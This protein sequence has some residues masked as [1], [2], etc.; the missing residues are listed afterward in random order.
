MYGLFLP[1]A[2]FF[3]NTT[4]IDI[5]GPTRANTTL[6]STLKTRQLS[7]YVSFEERYV[8]EEY[9]FLATYYKNDMT[10]I[11]A[12]L[13]LP[14]RY[15]EYERGRVLLGFN[16]SALN[17]DTPLILGNYEDLTAGTAWF[18]NPTSSGSSALA[19][20]EQDSYMEVFHSMQFSNNEY[21]Y[22]EFEQMTLPY[23]PYFS[24]CYGYDSYIPISELFEST[25]CA[26]PSDSSTSIHSSRY[27]YDPIPHQDDI[28]SVGPYDF[29]DRYP[30]ADWCELNFTCN[31]EEDLSLVLIALRWFEHATG[32]TL[33][34]LIDQPLSYANFTGRD[35]N[36]AGYYDAGSGEIIDTVTETTTDTLIN[37][38]VD[39]S[40]A[41]YLDYDC[42]S[43]CMPRSVQL[44]VGYYQK[45][46]REKQL[47]FGTLK[48]SDFDKDTTKTD[49][50]FSLSYYPL[51]YFDLIRYFVFDW[52]IFLLI[53]VIIGTVAAV[54]AII[55]YVIVY[56]T[57]RLENPPKLRVHS[58]FAL[59]APPPLIGC[60]LGLLPNIAIIALF[61]VLIN[62]YTI[63]GESS[64]NA[65]GGSLD[66]YALHYADDTYD[67]E[68]VE[69]ARVG[70]TGLCFV[71]LSILC[72]FV[73]ARI[74]LP[75]R[76][77]K[78]EKEIEK[79][80]DERANKESVW[81]PT[82][83]KRSNLIFTSYLAGLYCLLLFEFSFWS[84]F[85]TYYWTFFFLFAVLGEFT[86]TVLDNQ[87][88]EALLT[89][90]VGTAMGLT[91][92]A[93]T[94][95][96]SDF[97]DFLLG[98][99]VDYAISINQKVYIDQYKGDLLDF[100]FG[101]MDSI[102]EKISKRLPRRIV[103]ILGW[104]PEEEQ[105]EDGSK[106]RDLEGIV[107]EGA[108][109]VE[110]IL[111]VFGSHSCDTMSLFYTPFLIYMMIFFSSETQ[112]PSL[113]GIRDKDMLYYLLFAVVIIVFQLF[114][115][116]FILGTLE[117]YHGMKIYD[118]LVYTRYRFLQ[119]ETRWKGLEETLDECI[120]ETMRTLDQMCFSSQYYMM[121]T[122][123]TTGIMFFVFGVEMMLRA[124]YNMFGD[125]C[126][127]ILIP[128]V[129]VTSYIVVKI[130][131][132][133]A[134]KLN[135][136]KLKGENT[137]WASALDEDEDI[138][139]WDDIRGA[140]HDAYLMNQKITSETFRYKFLNYNRAWLINQLPSILTP[141]TL[142]RSRPYLINQ[143]TRILN[144]LNKD[145]SSDSEG[146]GTHKF[147]P[148]ALN[149]ASR[150]LIRW[151]LAQ[152][153]K[154]IKCRQV[155]APLI[156]KARGNH[157]EQCLSRKQLQVELVIPLEVMI[158]NFEKENPGGMTEFDQVG[159]KRYW[160]KHQRYET[161][162]LPCITKNRN[163]ER[164]EAM[165]RGGGGI[166]G[167]LTDSEGEDEDRPDFGPV[168]LSAASRAILL[169]W[170]RAAQDKVWKG[171]KG[172]RRKKKV[173]E[174]SDDEGEELVAEW[175]R[176]PVVIT[177][178]SKALAIKWLRTARSRL[179]Q[180]QAR[181]DMGRVRPGGRQK[182]GKKG[183][184]KTRRK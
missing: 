53:F 142:R 27:D 166:G 13:N 5:L 29:F 6:G 61:W 44:V 79:K 21:D 73:G 164:K 67:T 162:C 132:W 58:T 153:R 66:E 104:L 106:K 7:P 107:E 16:V 161:I 95:A 39:R 20:E 109:T 37:V 160:M 26:L 182:A 52:E 121:L 119:R 23:L 86:G 172:R 33:F 32:K 168:Y 133:I 10:T 83:W 71:I 124:E 147:G 139:G 92:G 65:V 60:I 151:W 137:A 98:F 82:V 167:G 128:Y 154:R 123:H 150:N 108:E 70:R 47:V 173:I 45:D 112:I 134:L 115:D 69:V 102:K 175:A 114:A 28:R 127:L 125:I 35:S 143:F 77:S 93:I 171:K 4:V 131:V 64:D 2:P 34:Q 105:A 57:S 90:P 138:P 46:T 89:A 169:G 54:A 163:D 15:S 59:I 85:G 159:W 157:C 17:S 56:F 51:N 25:E 68:L 117:L 78:R 136:W 50:L 146:D 96:A 49:Y 11:E 176:K 14:P 184:S 97:L 170:Y 174:V 88:K 122:I 180:R 145:I 19:K 42:S 181:S 110:P 91:E 129:T 12:P 18:S 72:I 63:V 144:Q 135:L 9:I 152:A 155:V 116:V 165:R 126:V 113:Y 183:R 177:E 38:K 100:I 81:I 101:V 76:V 99:Y 94:I 141:R 31:Y 30:I 8:P 74:F 40:A 48:L 111:D 148:V 156:A 1:V 36:R 80:R 158:E 62:V 178:A 87:L 24:N 120:D 75:K 41:N 43:Q 130:M 140:S 55:L 118:Y 22:G 149:A 3:K 103:K 179:Q 84:K